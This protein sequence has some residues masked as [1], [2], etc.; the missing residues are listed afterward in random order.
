MAAVRAAAAAA[1]AAEM[2]RYTRYGALAEV[3]QATQAAVAWNVILLPTEEGPVATVS[4]S[5]NLAYVVPDAL[6]SEWGG[7]I[8]GW[9]SFLTAYLLGATTR[10]AA[11]S[12]LIQAARSVKAAGGFVSNFQAGG[13]KSVDRTEPLVGSQVLARIYAKYGDAWLVEL[14]LDDLLDWSDWVWRSRRLEGV[15]G[16]IICLGSDP[17]PGFDLYSAGTM[18]GARF[19]SGLDDSPMYD[20]NAY[21]NVTHHMQLADV[22]ASVRRAIAT[23]SPSLPSP[24]VTLAPTLLPM[25]VTF[26]G[27]R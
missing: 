4:R 9:D 5:W 8:F 21:S 15:A 13:A 16:D 3:A 2:G 22:G 19:E 7:V 27:R 1:T 6:R 11:Y 14:L 20:F 17:V 10:D 26:C 18:Q 12:T 23:L 24:C 25:T